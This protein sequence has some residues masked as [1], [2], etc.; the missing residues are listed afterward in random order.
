MPVVRLSLLG[1]LD[2]AGQLAGDVDDEKDRIASRAQL[3]S[4]LLG[5]VDLAQILWNSS[6]VVAQRDELRQKGYTGKR[7]MVA[8]YVAGWRTADKGTMCTS[9]EP[10]AP[11][12]IRIVLFRSWSACERLGK[13]LP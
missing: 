13:K 5:G 11:K 1:V 8:H 12:P 4:H 3:G 10:I 6:R 2:P 7:A 9:A